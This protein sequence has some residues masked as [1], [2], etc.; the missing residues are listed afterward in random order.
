MVHWATTAKEGRL[1]GENAE[2]MRLRCLSSGRWRPLLELPWAVVSVCFFALTVPLVVFGG[3]GQY[4]FDEANYY[5]PSILSIRGSWPLLDLST[6]TLSAVAPGYS[7]FLAGV[8]FLTGTSVLSFRLVNLLVS[9][10]LIAFLYLWLRGSR[11]AVDSA[12]V[13]APLAASNFFVKSASWVVTD[14]AS[15]LVLT[16]S[17]VAMLSAGMGR[18]LAGSMLAGLATFVRQLNVW[19]TAP[20]LFRVLVQERTQVV[21]KGGGARRFLSWLP[22]SL[23]ALSPILMLAVLFAAWGGLVPPQWN[24]QAFKVSLSSGAYLFSVVA[25]FGAFYFGLG[26]VRTCVARASRG[27]LMIVAAAGLAIALVSPT[28][29]SY[30]DGRWGGYLWSLVALLPTIGGRSL[31]FVLLAP[32]GLAMAVALWRELRT[33]AASWR[34]D[35]WLISFGA[36][37]STFLVNRQVFHRYFEPTTLVLLILAFGLG[38]RQVL[39][40]RAR[41]RLAACAAIQVLGTLGTAFWRTFGS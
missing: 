36:W 11:S 34:A 24:Q 15:L 37:A 35:L 20:A 2:K 14:N 33:S 6:Q 32:L 38:D 9:Y 30:A 26:P 41:L 25:V 39:G 8:S 13:V 4:G 40:G 5:L 19:L 28:S 22:C 31:L 10:F 23:A 3:S 17:L 7:W 27:Q 18:S 29:M 21:G 16:A 12:L 1:F